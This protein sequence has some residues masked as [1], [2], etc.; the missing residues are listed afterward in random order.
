MKAVIYA[1]FSS[2]KQ[3]EVSIE[4]RLRECMDYTNFNNIEV[5]G[6][7]IDR[8]QSEGRPTRGGRFACRSIPPSWRTRRHCRRSI[9]VGQAM[10]VLFCVGDPDGPE[11]TM[12]VTR[13]RRR[14]RRMIR[15]SVVSLLTSDMRRKTFL[16]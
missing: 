5:I 9:P 12:R 8:A 10:P 14:M 11:E 2:E 3:N 1:R 4:G 16:L 7:Y 13:S 6:N 15:Y